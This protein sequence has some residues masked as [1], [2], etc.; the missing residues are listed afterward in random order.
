VITLGEIDKLRE[1]IR[2][3]CHMTIDKNF[4]NK[5]YD[6]AI[7]CLKNGDTFM[8]NIALHLVPNDMI[9]M[10]LI[11]HDGA[12]TKALYKKVIETKKEFDI[13]GD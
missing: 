2:V 5:E 6:D 11:E 8:I 4:D 1:V 3:V 9:W 13:P 12:I 10:E 7:Q